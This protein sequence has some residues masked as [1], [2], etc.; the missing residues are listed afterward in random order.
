MMMIGPNGSRGLCPADWQT[1]RDN[2]ALGVGDLGV[3]VLAFTVLTP[4][5]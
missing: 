4:P 2:I 5:T 3:S 1:I